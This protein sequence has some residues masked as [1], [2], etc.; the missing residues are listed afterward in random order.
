MTL[1]SEECLHRVGDEEGREGD[2]A[3]RDRPGPHAPSGDVDVQV[4]A[5]RFAHTSTVPPMIPPG[6]TDGVAP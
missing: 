6:N 4:N 1:P 2:H 5:R 3:D